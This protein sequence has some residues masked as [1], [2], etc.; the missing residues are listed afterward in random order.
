MGPSIGIAQT[1]TAASSIV[2]SIRRKSSD[3]SKKSREHGLF[4]TGDQNWHI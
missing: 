4:D 2:V 3:F 1:G